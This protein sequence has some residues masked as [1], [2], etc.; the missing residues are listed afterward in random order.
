MQF[1]R[2]TVNNNNEHFFTLDG[3]LDERRKSIMRSFARDF[4]RESK[5]RERIDFRLTNN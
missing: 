2:A 5:M 4:P 3:L 1:I